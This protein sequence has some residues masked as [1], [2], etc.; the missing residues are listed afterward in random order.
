MLFEG[1]LLGDCY[2]FGTLCASQDPLVL[3]QYYV[4]IY[5]KFLIALMSKPLLQSDT[6]LCDFDFALFLEY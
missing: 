3:L 1:K 4:H 6:W 5:D 2:Q